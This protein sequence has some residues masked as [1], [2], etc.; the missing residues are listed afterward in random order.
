MPLKTERVGEYDSRS[1]PLKKLEPFIKGKAT[2][3]SGLPIILLK[4]KSEGKEGKSERKRHK[5]ATRGLWVPMQTQ[6]KHKLLPLLSSSSSKISKGLRAI[7][8]YSA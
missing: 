5:E 4:K 7:N 3:C 1:R 2:E 8:L 6:N